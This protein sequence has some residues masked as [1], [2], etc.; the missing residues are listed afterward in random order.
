[1][2]NDLVQFVSEKKSQAMANCLLL[3]LALNNNKLQNKNLDADRAKRIEIDVKHFDGINK[4]IADM[5]RVYDVMLMPLHISHQQSKRNINST[6]H[7]SL[8]FVCWIRNSE[9]MFNN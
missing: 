6:K 5:Y 3:L 8:Y 4:Y 1:M 2:R 7:K 9:G